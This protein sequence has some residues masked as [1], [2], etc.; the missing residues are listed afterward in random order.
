MAVKSNKI[1]F[2]V[3]DDLLAR[4]QAVS[5]VILPGEV[6]PIPKLIRMAVEDLSVIPSL[7][8]TTTGK[9]PCFQSL[10]VFM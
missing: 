5:E 10:T 3:D 6:R 1:M 4:M 9:M 2:R 7:F 8:L